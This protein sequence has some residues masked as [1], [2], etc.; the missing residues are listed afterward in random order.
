M[1]DWVSMAKTQTR[2][3]SRL[4]K[5]ALFP[6]YVRFTIVLGTL[7]IVQHG[8]SPAAILFPF[9]QPENNT[10]PFSRLRE[11]SNGAQFN[12]DYGGYLRPPD[13]RSKYQLGGWA[14]PENIFT[15][16][17]NRGRRLGDFERRDYTTEADGTL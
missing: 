8:L 14:G 5:T 10:R 11:G 13:P 6:Q 15:T 17:C 16:E 12:S 1:D 7:T 4:G 3:R 2:S 9:D